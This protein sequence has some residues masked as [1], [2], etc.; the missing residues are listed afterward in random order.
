MNAPRI[1][2]QLISANSAVVSEGHR[3]PAN[4]R[5]ERHSTQCRNDLSRLSGRDRHQQGK[6]PH[7]PR[8]T[9][10]IRLRIV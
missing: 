1:G 8:D 5:F 2:Q 10:P 9:G 3:K 4:A 7:P 6:A